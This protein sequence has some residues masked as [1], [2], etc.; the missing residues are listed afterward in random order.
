MARIELCRFAN[1]QFLVDMN[2]F[3]AHIGITLEKFKYEGVEIC[4]TFLGL[5]PL[6]NVMV[7]I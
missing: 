7:N 4:M 1:R 5:Y 6:S 3:L 2:C